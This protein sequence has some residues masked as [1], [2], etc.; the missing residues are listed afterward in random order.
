MCQNCGQKEILPCINDYVI[1]WWKNNLD[2]LRHPFALLVIL[3]RHPT[4]NM[5]QIC[6]Y[7]CIVL[8]KRGNYVNFLC[9]QANFSFNFLEYE[10]PTFLNLSTDTK[11]IL[12]KAHPLSFSFSLSPLPLSLKININWHTVFFFLFMQNWT[13]HKV[14]ISKFHGVEIKIT[15][16][17]QTCQNSLS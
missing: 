17:R 1:V 8:W 6:F 13:K 12:L 9:D 16:V 10:A 7:F 11:N 3:L 5:F 15:Q 14:R 2:K 4:S